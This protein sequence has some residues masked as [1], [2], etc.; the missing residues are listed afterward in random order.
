MKIALVSDTHGLDDPR[1]PELFRGC[2]R[3][4]H[5]GDMVRPPVLESLARVAP[6]TAVRGNNDLDPCFAGLPETVVLP[7]GGLR[8]F[9]VHDLGARERPRPPASAALVRDRPDLV[10]HGHTHRPGTALHAGRLYVNPGSAGP[11]RFT[12]PRTAAI[13]TVSGRRARVAF[14]DLSGPRI[15]AHGAP[16]EADL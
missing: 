16:M 10:V 8:V 13:L 6:V 5:A 1:L 2:E 12:L 14:F 4:L 7:V 15:E 9:L 3:V 11:R